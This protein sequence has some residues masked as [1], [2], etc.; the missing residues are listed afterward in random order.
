MPTKQTELN[1]AW[2]EKNKARQKYL[3][4]RSYA[5]IFIRDLATEEDIEFLNELIEQRKH[6]EK[7]E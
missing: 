5:K 6:G 2:Q 4:Y 7:F 3:N 1:K